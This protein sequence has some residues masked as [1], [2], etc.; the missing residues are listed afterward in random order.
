MRRRTSG[1]RRA[2]ALDLD[3]PLPHN[4]DELMN[5]GVGDIQPHTACQNCIL[6]VSL[7]GAALTDRSGLL[8]AAL[9]PGFA[10]PIVARLPEKDL[11]LG[12]RVS[13]CLDG[14]ETCSSAPEWG[15]TGRDH[16]T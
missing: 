8:P 12:S 16:G 4:A 10:D 11:S 2:C 15:H 7:G 1:A 14:G 3:R 13:C 9:L 6:V 5:R